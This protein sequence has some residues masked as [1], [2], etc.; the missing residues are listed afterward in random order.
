MPCEYVRWSVV[1]KLPVRWA[2]AVCN[3]IC[4]MIGYCVLM[5]VVLPSLITYK[6]GPCFRARLSYFLL[7]FVPNYIRYF[8][9]GLYW[10]NTSFAYHF[11]S[12]S[13]GIVQSV[14]SSLLMTSLSLVPA[15]FAGF[16]CVRSL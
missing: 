11:T 15:N 4:F 2:A 16:P 7:L 13:A 10:R 12:K 8:V 3:S 1:C 14:M 5:P 6:K 9:Q